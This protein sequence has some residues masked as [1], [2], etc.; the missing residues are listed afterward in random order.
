M[1]KAAKKPA[2]RGVHRIRT[3][4]NP[5]EVIEVGEAEFLDL[6][7]QGLIYEGKVSELE[8]P[9]APDPAIVEPGLITSP[10]H[11]KEVTP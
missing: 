1:A 10:I 6:T 4:I 7:R 8:E 9:T 11:D 2:P 5:R 3:T